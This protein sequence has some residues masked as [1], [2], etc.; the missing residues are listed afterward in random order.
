VVIVIIKMNAMPEKCLEL[1]QSLLALVDPIRR[2]KGCLSHSIFQ[3]IENDNDFSLI[4][5]WQ[6]RDDLDAYLRSDLFTVLIGTRYLLSRPSGISVN[7]VTHASQ[8]E[9]AEAVRG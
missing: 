1:K 3:D 2:E 5:M 9:A 4:Q 6:T 7:E 8:W